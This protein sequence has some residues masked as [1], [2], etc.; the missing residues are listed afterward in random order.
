MEKIVIIGS[1]GAGKST[2]A[3][4][5]GCTLGIK[6]VIHLDR[7]FWKPGWKEFSRE[8]RKEIEQGLIS[9]KE[10]WI[11]E[12]TFLS[13]S[14]SRLQAADTIIFLDMLSPLCLQQA[15]KRYITYRKQ[16]SPDISAR[17]DMPPECK[18][19]LGLFYIL[20]IL[21]FPYKGRRLF[22]KKITKIQVAAKSQGIEKNFLI[23][24]SHE[25]SSDFLQ[26]LSAYQQR[27]L[28]DQQQE[29]HIRQEEAVLV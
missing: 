9:G 3:Q 15:V 18:E 20:K 10:Q 26:A 7:Y 6:E 29:V 1:P 13:S 24:R 21:V 16:K 23:C 11:I 12:G 14:D 5:L 17:P 8:K 27:A 4:A 2:L 25:I 22:F 19:K 28:S